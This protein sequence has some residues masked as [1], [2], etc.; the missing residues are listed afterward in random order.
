M[1]TYPGVKE[2]A[3]F[4]KELRR[5]KYLRKRVKYELRVSSV[6]PVLTCKNN[7]IG[8]TNTAYRKK[9]FIWKKKKTSWSK[10]IH[11]FSID[12]PEVADADSTRR[13]IS[14]YLRT[15]ATF[16]DSYPVLLVTPTDIQ[17]CNDVLVSVVR[18][19]PGTVVV[20]IPNEGIRPF[21]DTLTETY[22]EFA[23]VTPPNASN[24]HRF[25]LAVLRATSEK[26]LIPI[27][28]HNSSFYCY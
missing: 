19:N 2:K 21:A 9:S 28:I 11:I 17:N 27:F 26:T 5:R 24:K 3:I 20:A 18:E 15:S 14:Q 7:F 4:E 25:L 1:F 22:K 8:L 16:K 23:K 6:N 13:A 12:S 10:Y